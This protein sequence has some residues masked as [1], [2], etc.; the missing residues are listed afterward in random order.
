MCT[1]DCTDC[2]TLYKQT[3]FCSTFGNSKTEFEFQMLER[4]IRQIYVLKNVSV[5]IIGGDIFKYSNLN[6]L[7]NLLA[8][9]P[10]NTILNSHYLNLPEV[11]K[12]ENEIR[13][14]SDLEFVIFVSLPINKIAFKKTFELIKKFAHKAKFKFT[15]AD[16]NDFNKVE[17]IVKTYS[18]DNFEIVPYFN[19]RNLD[20]FNE[21]VYLDK[22]DLQDLSL[23]MNEIFANMSI[24]SLSFGKFNINPKGEVY[25]NYWFEPVGSIYTDK[26]HKLIYSEISTGKGWRRIR[27]NK[28]CNECIYQFLCPPPTNFELAIGNN[29]ICNC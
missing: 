16:E 13:E 6:D 12:Y 8:E 26:L 22:C 14:I 1:H 10:S 9:N 17:Q 4:F 28:P 18:L 3:E 29:K 11:L 25:S 21:N 7:L 2:Q 23:K 19:G 5:N 27:N 15:I 24:N 20:F